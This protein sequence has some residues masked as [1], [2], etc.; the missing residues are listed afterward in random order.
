[1]NKGIISVNVPAGGMTGI[2]TVHPQE[3]ANG[4]NGQL[5]AIGQFLGKVL[6]LRSQFVLEGYE[7]C[8]EVL[9]A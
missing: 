3:I 1:M 6:A 9:F 8:D 5:K 4:M 7:L 2:I